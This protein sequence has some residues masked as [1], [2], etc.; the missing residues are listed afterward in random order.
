MVWFVPDVTWLCSSSVLLCHALSLRLIFTYLRCFVA[1]L[2]EGGCLYHVCIES[3]SIPIFVAEF[4]PFILSVAIRSAFIL[5]L[6][7]LIVCV[8]SPWLDIKDFPCQSSRRDS[9]K[10]MLLLTWFVRAHLYY[11]RTVFD[12]FLTVS[13]I[14]SVFYIYL[15]R[16]FLS[17]LFLCPK[18]SFLRLLRWCPCLRC[19][20]SGLYVFLPPRVFSRP[21]S[22]VYYTAWLK[23]MDSVLYVYIS[24]TIHG[25]RMIYITFERG[26]KF[27]YITARALAWHIAVQQRQLRARWLLCS[28]IYLTF[29]SSLK[30]VWRLLCS[31]RV[32][33]ISTF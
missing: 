1:S 5:L 18:P 32:F 4:S 31:L 7:Y 9:Q 23:K 21:F 6:H 2:L 14:C 24:L 26:I 11:F 28:P 17:A 29:V 33:F 15:H 20:L 22:L 19:C 10:F 12:V 30:L 25:M 27:S 3:L 16:C 13:I 8:N